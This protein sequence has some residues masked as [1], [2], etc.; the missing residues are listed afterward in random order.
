MK[1]ITRTAL[2]PYSAKLIYDL[3]NDVESYPE[4]LPWCGNA[5]VIESSDQ[6]MVA[7]VTISKMGLNQTFVTRNQLTEPS[8]INMTLVKGPFSHLVGTWGFKAL[9]DDACKIEFEVEFEVSSS[10]LSAAISTVF[11]QIASTFVQSF[12]ERAKVVYG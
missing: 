4:F 9:S 3:V 5:E 10:L 11:E 6:Q 1:K 12:C 2:L 7:G 8:E